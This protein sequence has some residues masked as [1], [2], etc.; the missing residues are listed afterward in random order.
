MPKG[1]QT[2]AVDPAG[3]AEQVRELAV[4]VADLHKMLGLILNSS[5]EFIPG[6]SIEELEDAWINSSESSA[7]VV[8]KLNLMARA[9]REAP[10]K[11]K[12]LQHKDD[13]LTVEALRKNELLGP[14][15]TAK[16]SSLRRLR[17]AFYSLWHT[18][19]RSSETRAKLAEASIDWLELG[20]TVLSSLKV[21]H[22]AEEFFSLVRQL[23]QAKRKHSDDRSSDPIT[24]TQ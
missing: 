17:D 2:P 15:G 10:A 8:T 22:Y 5:H 23:M 16:R 14:I 13:D 4:A 12:P 7:T 18:Q 11:S 3:D 6:E 21:C 9:L 19:P 24:A 20:G 1:T